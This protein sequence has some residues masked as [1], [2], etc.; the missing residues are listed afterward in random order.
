MYNLHAI[1]HPLCLRG[2]V[3]SLAI[4][5]LFFMYNNPTDKWL[6]RRGNSYLPSTIKISHSDL[7][8]LLQSANLPGKVTLLALIT[9]FLTASF[10]FLA[11]SLAVL[12]NIAL[13]TIILASFS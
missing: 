2:W 7:F 10:A 1:A 3:P 11:L 9:V 5:P 12:A 4:I 8:L 13:F 6:S